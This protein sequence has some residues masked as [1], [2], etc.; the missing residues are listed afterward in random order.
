MM[1]V[2]SR[3]ERRKVGTCQNN[4]LNG[5]FPIVIDDTTVEMNV[6]LMTLGCIRAVN[7]CRDH[8]TQLFYDDLRSEDEQ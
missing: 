6:S 3:F 8:V 1:V 7:Y 2:V 5:I 4:K